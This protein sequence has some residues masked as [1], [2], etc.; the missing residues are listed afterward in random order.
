MKTTTKEQTCVSP[1]TWDVDDDINWGTREEEPMDF[2]RK[3]VHCLSIKE[4]VR[5]GIQHL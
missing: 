3:W 5:P 2:E 1:R 4:D